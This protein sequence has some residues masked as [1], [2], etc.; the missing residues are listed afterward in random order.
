MPA[1]YA[2]GPDGRPKI[3]LT[4]DDAFQSVF[5]FAVPEMVKRNMPST[6]FVPTAC[7]GAAPT[8]EMEYNCFDR[9]EI[10]ACE[11]T[12]RAAARDGIQL[13]AHA[14]THPRLTAIAPDGAREEI[15]GSKAD[16][17]RLLG[18]PVDT[19]SFPYGDFN[20]RTVQYCKEAGYRYAYSITP[21][22]VDLSDGAMLRPR[23]AVDPSDTKL[24]FWLKLRGAYSWMRLASLA[25]N[26][27][28]GRR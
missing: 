15:A 27:L 25:K 24:E 3:A 14:R 26:Q 19:F 22:L 7:I 20:E 16:L 6:I 18:R 23:I 1:D 13:G 2:G 9:N 10:L 17:E 12:L 5:D 4:F 21:A 28:R 11:E 8:W